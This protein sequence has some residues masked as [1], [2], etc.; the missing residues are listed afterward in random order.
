MVLPIPSSLVATAAGAL[1]GFPLGVSAVFGGLMACN[2]VGYGL[3]L[4]LGR[5][6]LDPLFGTDLKPTRQ[7]TC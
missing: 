3:R 5:Q 6:A 2:L 7:A 1:L 4:G